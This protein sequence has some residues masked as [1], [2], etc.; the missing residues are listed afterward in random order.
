ML[1]SIP[2]AL[3]LDSFP[4]NISPELLKDPT[5][6]E[7]YQKVME[8]PELADALLAEPDETIVKMAV[9]R[10]KSK[11]SSEIEPLP[12]FV[13]KTYLKAPKD[14]YASGMKVFINL[15]HSPHVPSPPFATDEEI[16]RALNAEDNAA[17]RVP[18][19]LLG[20]REDVDK[21]SKPCLVFDVCIN[22][23]P[24]NKG[25]Q[26]FQYK[27]FLIELAI[28]WI[29]NKHKLELGR[30]YTQPK[31]KSKGSLGKHTIYRAKKPIIADVTD[32]PKP[33]PLISSSG[34]PAGSQKTKSS[35]A[36]SAS[37]TAKENIGLEVKS[38]R[39]LRPS[40]QSTKETSNSS[41]AAATQKLKTPQYEMK[42]ENGSPKRLIIKVDLPDVE[43]TK[44]AEL[45]IESN[46]MLFTLPGRYHL[47]VPLPVAGLRLTS[48]LSQLDDFLE[49]YEAKMMAATLHKDADFLLARF[50]QA[51]LSA[52]YNLITPDSERLL[53]NS[54]DKANALHV[55]IA[56]MVYRGGGGDPEPF[57]R[58]SPAK[59]LLDRR[60]SLE[61][62]LRDM[63][64]QYVDCRW[65]NGNTGLHLAAYL[66]Q[67]KIVSLLIEKGASTTETND[68]GLT[69]FDVA[70]GRETQ[71][72]LS[73]TALNRTTTTSELHQFDQPRSRNPSWPARMALRSVTF[74]PSSSTSSTSAPSS[75]SSSS[76]SLVAS[77]FSAAS[78]LNALTLS[79]NSTPSKRTLEMSSSP[80]KTSEENSQGPP[81]TQR[82]DAGTTLVSSLDGGGLTVE[83]ISAPAISSSSLTI[84]LSLPL[85]VT[86]SVPP[87]S[88][89]MTSS[90]GLSTPIAPPSSGMFV[91]ASAAHPPTSGKKHSDMGSPANMALDFTF[92]C[93]G[94]T[95]MPAIPPAPTTMIVESQTSVGISLK[96]TPSMVTQQQGKKADAQDENGGR[97]L[98]TS[99]SLASSSSSSSDVQ[100]PNHQIRIVQHRTAAIDLGDSSDL[101][102]SVAI[103]VE[104]QPT[105]CGVEGGLE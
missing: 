53:G 77:P 97:A 15:C 100:S 104:V 11:P 33:A 17:Y 18:M 90:L 29:E 46:R 8:D 44:D 61:T 39:L 59:L 23:D 72:K 83:N 80:P 75:T 58:R 7:L 14:K 45:H 70:S 101:D 51:C 66:D 103:A 57:L 34:K 4:G 21:T 79:S 84:S 43:T 105:M 93:D 6:R 26:D 49:P 55:V 81:K 82:L 1:T 68:L 74:M 76:S 52:N 69:P 31:M 78:T 42:T 62:M 9:E 88:H 102:Q 60:K 50:L 10:S 64:P 3:G 32:S 37:T 73:R 94:P 25:N 20:P 27:L 63:P 22:S 67:P 54:V 41:G 47:D 35:T 12:G 28:S 16:R 89:L 71:D 91:G 96:D 87:V 40:P 30:D 19:S 99:S 13:I 2:D 56:I 92:G 5:F 48:N 38:S 85:S 36:P 65:G 95:D 86:T 24:L 98:S